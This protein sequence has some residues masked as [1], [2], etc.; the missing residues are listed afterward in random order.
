MTKYTKI[1]NHVLNNYIKKL[2]INDMIPFELD[3]AE[4]FKISRMTVNKAINALVDEGYLKRI[5]GKG[6]FIV[7]KSSNNTK[8]LGELYSYSEDMHK[9]NAKPLTKILDYE[10]IERA[11]DANI[12]LMGLSEGDS[13][14]KI[15]RLRYLNNKPISI[16]YTYIPTKYIKDLDHSKLSDSMLEYYEGEMGIIIGYEDQ[17]IKAAVADTEL[18]KILEVKKGSPL[19]RI[20]GCMTNQYEEIFE[21]SIVYYVSDAY[22]LKKRAYR[23][24]N[25]KNKK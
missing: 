16:D 8:D 1:Y 9:R 10:Y 25:D 2:E 22:K 13:L 3:L 6:T 12:K 23:P 18:S 24:N 19:L 7:A 20:D 5:K 4:E 14:H 21:H 15:V 11:D 17:E